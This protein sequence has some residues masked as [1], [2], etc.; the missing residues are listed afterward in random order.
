MMIGATH[1]LEK[2]F[3]ND[4]GPLRLARRLGIAAVNRIP[5]L[6]R[7]FARQAMGLPLGGPGILRSRRIA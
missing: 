2:L 4:I 5:M 7:G 3:A 1:L 6:K